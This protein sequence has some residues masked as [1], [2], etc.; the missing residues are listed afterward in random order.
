MAGG[1]AAKAVLENDIDQLKEY[2]LEIQEHLFD[3]LNRAFLKKKRL[4]GFW[5]GGEVDL[6]EALRWGWVGFSD[7][8]KNERCEAT[9]G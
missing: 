7:Y 1:Y 2:E 9:N 6:A 4:E 8:Y 5:Q 3:S